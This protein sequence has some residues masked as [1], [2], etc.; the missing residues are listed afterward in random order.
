MVIQPRSV[1]N[2]VKVFS[3]EDILIFAAS[4]GDLVS[5]GAGVGALWGQSGLPHH[6]SPVLQ[7]LRGEST[8]SPGI[9]AVINFYINPD[10]QI[11]R[12]QLQRSVLQ[13]EL[14]KVSKV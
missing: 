7:H 14:F 11:N 9:Y 10:V 12:T 4:T 1:Q 2:R 6:Q 5:D 3:S 8:C 13:Q